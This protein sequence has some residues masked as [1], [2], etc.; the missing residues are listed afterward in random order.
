[1]CICRD[2][3][4][5]YRILKEKVKEYDRKEAQFYGSIL[6]KMSKLEQAESAVSEEV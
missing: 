5:G 4:K 2:V 6:K 1:M 3:K